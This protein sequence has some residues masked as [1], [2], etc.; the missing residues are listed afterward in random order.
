MSD[1]LLRYWN[2]FHDFA[3]AFRG[4]VYRRLPLALLANFY[5]YLPEPLKERMRDPDCNIGAAAIRCRK[6]VGPAFARL[7]AP[8]LRPARRGLPGRLLVH[9]D[10]VRLPARHY[11]ELFEPDG[12]LLLG[13]GG[14]PTLFGHP[15]LNIHDYA[16]DVTNAVRL[17][18][19]RARQA[20]KTARFADPGVARDIA[21]RFLDDLPRMAQ[22]VEAV[23]RL[24][25]VH[26]VSC[27]LVGTTEDL[28]SRSLVMAAGA[29]GIPSI[30]LQ[31]GLIMGEEAYMPVFATCMAVYG[32]TELAWY[33]A[34]GVARERIAVTGHPRHDLLRVR[35]SRSRGEVLE[36]AGLDPGTPTALVATQPSGGADRWLPF[37]RRLTGYGMQVIVKP[38]PLEIGR[39]TAGEYGHAFRLLPGVR[40]IVRHAETADLL[41]A[42]DAVAV[43]SSTVGLEALL[44]GKPL[45]V[46]RDRQPDRDY[47]YFEGL[48]GFVQDNPE[49]LAAMLHA[50]VVH[51][52]WAERI[53]EERRRFLR[54][55]YPVCLSGPVLAKLIAGWTG[56]RTGTLQAAFAGRLVKGSGDGVFR[57][58]NGMKRHIAGLSVFV[59][60]GF[61][62]EDVCLVD[63]R[64]LARIPTGPAIFRPDGLGRER[65]DRDVLA[66]RM[67]G[68]LV[69]GSG[70]EVYLLDRGLKRHIASEQAFARMRFD[71]ERVCRLDDRILRCIP[72]GPFIG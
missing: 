29:R 19:G 34:R 50:A 6:D 30:C 70:P 52:R 53:R 4:V 18:S 48:A 40:V 33:L 41:A 22:T 35:A 24:L 36:E 60:A 67:N 32:R 3:E 72:S 59:E 49:K 47:D 63:D 10:Y 68:L 58:E 2:L 14:P 23:C 31:H 8:V 69:Q 61:R 43:Q 17:L 39:G 54:G 7:M 66:G 5:K 12:T 13:R 57:I 15:L 28:L 20:A 38:H 37:V 27:V 21:G 64:I 46:L 1:Y 16:A 71:W 26:R 62:W 56:R 25:D 45:F 51:G 11:H 42:A 44:L 9:V 65:G 55:A